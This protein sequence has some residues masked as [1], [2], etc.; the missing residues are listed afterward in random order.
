MTQ[1]KALRELPAAAT[2]AMNALLSKGGSGNATKV[3][4]SVP[5][6]NVLNGSEVNNLAWMEQQVS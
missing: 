6:G 4:A 3:A 5:A 2:A 1:V